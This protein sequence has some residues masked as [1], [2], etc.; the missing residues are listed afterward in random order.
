[1]NS[2]AESFALTLSRASRQAMRFLRTRGVNRDARDDVI[3]A[4]LLWC[5]ENQDNYSLTATLEQWFLGAIRHAY[6]DYLR[7]EL[8]DGVTEIIQ[9]MGGKD[10]PEYNAMLQEAVHTLASNMDEIDRAIVQL[11][12]DGKNQ[13][14]IR[15]ALDMGHATVERRL[16]RMRAQI[17]ASAHTN[18]ILR[19]AVT[20]AAQDTAES[21]VDHQPRIDKEI[22]ALEFAPPAGKECPPCFY[23]KWFEGY[24]PSMRKPVRMEIQERSVKAAVLWTER[25][26]KRIA[27]QVR[28]G[29]L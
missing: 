24:M 27:Q 22:E 9:D 10:D 14:E 5:W 2:A 16:A 20:S 23:C 1:M 17:P 15:T 28:D 19:R 6:R 18:T 21:S 29:T 3:A 26:K 8:R 12:L 25:R 11:T 4:A 7:G 13:R